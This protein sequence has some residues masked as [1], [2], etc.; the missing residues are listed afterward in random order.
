MVGGRWKL[1]IGEGTTQEVRLPLLLSV[2]LLVLLYKRQAQESKVPLSLKQ[3]GGRE[4]EHG[5]TV[6]IHRG[7]E[8]MSGRVQSMQSTKL[9][10][11]TVACSI[12]IQLYKQC[13]NVGLLDTDVGCVPWGRNFNWLLANRK[14]RRDLSRPISGQIT[15]RALSLRSRDCSLAKLPIAVEKDELRSCATI[16]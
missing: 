14:W 5:H 7:S 13:K 3:V 10:T 8:L 6:F 9:H 4:Q 1:E 11:M 16:S 12:T 15:C 2:R